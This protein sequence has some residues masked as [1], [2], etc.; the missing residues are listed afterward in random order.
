[1]TGDSDNGRIGAVDLLLY[2]IIQ[3]GEV[4]S[5]ELLDLKKLLFGSFIASHDYE[6]LRV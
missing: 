6:L 2:Q 5:Y 1:M 4:A 3:V